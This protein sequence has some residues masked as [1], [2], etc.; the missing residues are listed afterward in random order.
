VRAYATH[1]A[2]TKHIFHIKNLHLGH[3]AKSFALA[4]PPSKLV[5]NPWPRSLGNNCAPYLD[6]GYA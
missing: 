1:S 4:E 2:A 3:V 6:H 5:R